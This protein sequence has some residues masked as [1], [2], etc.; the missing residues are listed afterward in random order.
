MAD[1]L[2]LVLVN[3]SLNETRMMLPVVCTNINGYNIVKLKYLM[4]VAQFSGKSR[5]YE[6][7]LRLN[8]EN[9][10][11]LLGALLLARQAVRGSPTYPEGQ[12]QMAPWF[13]A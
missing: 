3:I 2:L 5:K 1:L 9:P 8:L 13:L 11:T 12:E 7:R 6:S 10:T 4:S